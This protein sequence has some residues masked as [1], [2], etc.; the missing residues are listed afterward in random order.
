MGVVGIVWENVK[1]K[2]FSDIRPEY[3]IWLSMGNS[4]FP[5]TEPYGLFSVYHCQFP[6]EGLKSASTSGF[7]RLKRYDVV[8]LNSQYTYLWYNIY[9]RT[10]RLQIQPPSR[11]SRHIQLPQVVHFPPPFNLEGG[12]KTS[13][14]EDERATPFFLHSE[15]NIILI[16]RFFDGVQCKNHE[17]AIKAFQMLQTMLPDVHVRLTL[18]GHVATGHQVYLKKIQQLAKD[19]KQIGIVKDADKTVLEN[20]IRASDIVWSITGMLGHGAKHPHADEAPQDPADA[21]HFGIGLLECMSS[22]IIPV[23]V[24]RGGPREILHGLPEFLRVTSVIELAE[25]TAELFSLTETELSSLRERSRLR[26]RELQLGFIEGCHAMFT[27]LGKTLSPSIRDI[28]FPIKK[29]VREHERLFTLE[30]QAEDLTSCP[31]MWADTLAILYV[32]ERIDMSF[33]AVMSILSDKL[34][35]DWRLHV[36]H[37]DANALHVEYSLEGFNCVVYHSLRDVKLSNKPLTPRSAGEYQ[38]IWKSLEFFEALG[39]EVKHVMTFQ[40]DTWFP[41]MGLFQEQWLANDF[42]GPPWCHEGNWGYLDPAD[43]PLE[44]VKMLHDTRKIPFDTRVGNG[45]VSIRSVPAMKSVLVAHLQDSTPQENEDV[46]YAFF[47]TKDHFRVANLSDAVHFGLEILCEDI[48]EHVMLS[49]DFQSSS[50]VPFALH[51]PFDIIQMLNVHHGVDLGVIV[52]SLF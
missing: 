45:G 3:D 9:L 46:F 38:R 23:A 36:W 2:L 47:L 7:E 43:R 17:L 18:V 8:Y 15:I 50:Y 48:G 34:E 52:K 10:F 28:W 6:F 19:N 44:S 29:S 20:L 24:D 37:S 49:K 5:E 39:P 22:G 16:G 30:P 21:E 32:E 4:L 51:K 14:L 35:K 11:R 41:P 12:H 31:P 42:I 33:R 27:L 40:S 26:A 25:S 1:V 13:S